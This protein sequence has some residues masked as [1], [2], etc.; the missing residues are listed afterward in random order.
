MSLE[1]HNSP[2]N[3]DKRQQGMIY[4][5]SNLATPT[6]VV[7]QQHKQVVTIVTNGILAHPS[8]S[9]RFCCR[10]CAFLMEPKLSN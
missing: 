9:D 3:T 5:I 2:T 6:S 10:P 4:F 1:S 7:L 8:G